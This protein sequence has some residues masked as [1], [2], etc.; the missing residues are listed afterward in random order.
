MKPAIKVIQG[1]A[2]AHG[3]LAD[4][5]VF[6]LFFLIYICTKYV[7]QIN[8]NKGKL[9]VSMNLLN[10]G[11]TVRD[12]RIVTIKARSSV[13]DLEIMARSSQWCTYKAA[14]H[15]QIDLE[16]LELL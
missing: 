5:K 10:Y 8:T 13:T 7:F 14:F 2:L 11:N 12:S 6:N 3:V 4:N 16:L 1:Q 15:K 9:I